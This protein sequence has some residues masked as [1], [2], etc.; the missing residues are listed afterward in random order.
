MWSVKYSSGEIFCSVSPRYPSRSVRLCLLSRFLPSSP[1]TR[2]SALSVP[3]CLRVS[4]RWSRSKVSERVENMQ[5]IVPQWAPEPSNVTNPPH[6]WH[7]TAKTE[8]CGHFDTICSNF[9]VFVVVC[10]PLCGCLCRQSY[11]GHFVSICSF[12]FNSILNPQVDW[13]SNKEPRKS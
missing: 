3:L 8:S 12:H 2:L 4:V 7:K 9:L 1:L 11:C 5:Q 13:L 6:I 10:L